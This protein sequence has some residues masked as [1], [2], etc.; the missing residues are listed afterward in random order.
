MMCREEKKP[1]SIK[2]AASLHH[3]NHIICNFPPSVFGQFKQKPPN[4]QFNFIQTHNQPNICIHLITKLAFLTALIIRSILFTLLFF[5]QP[6]ETN[7]TKYAIVFPNSNRLFPVCLLSAPQTVNEVFDPQMECR[8]RLVQHQ[9]ISR[10]LIVLRLDRKKTMQAHRHRKR[11][12][13]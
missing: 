9:P 10:K 6:F 8:H 13:Q 3:K 1:Y 12:K 5:P 2:L 4:L 11:C 7:M